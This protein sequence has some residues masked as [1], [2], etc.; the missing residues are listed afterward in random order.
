MLF[1]GIGNLGLGQRKHDMSLENVLHQKTMKLITLDI[2]N[3]T[4][5]PEHQNR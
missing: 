5:D 3:D 1:E 2:F 4:K